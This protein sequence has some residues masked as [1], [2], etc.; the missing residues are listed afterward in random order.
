MNRVSIIIPTCGRP[1]KLWNCLRAL[2][3]Q[4]LPE[5][6]EQEIIVAVD[7]GWD[8]SDAGSIRDGNPECRFLELPRVGA[9]AARNA[10]IA[11]ATG[12][13]LIFSNDDT[14]PGPDWVREHL[15]AQAARREPG[16]VI[17]ETRWIEWPDMTVL[18]G[19]LR[20]TSMVFFYDRMKS[21]ESYGFRH[22]W[23]CNASA[24]REMVVG[25]GGFEESL[26]PVFYEDC[27]LAFRI[28]K[29]FGSGVYFHSAAVNV[30]DHRLSWSDYLQRE[31]ALGRMAIVLASVNPDCF[32]AIF[33]RR[34]VNVMAL[35]YHEWL[36]HDRGDHEAVDRLMR[37][38]CEGPLT[39]S[40][41]WREYCDVLYR[42]HLPLKRR[43]FRES[44]VRAASGL[45]ATPSE[46]AATSAG[47]HRP[48]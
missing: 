24:P 2:R 43:I 8:E 4:S 32:E 14:Y 25:V 28:E 44:F 1:R 30:H 19:L 29:T 17:G 20:D 34:D 36:N 37:S 45:T 9:A 38:V 35:E 6:V 47:T 18:D 21:G 22:F 10:A 39:E 13:L 46:R 3:H 31:S 26:R 16:M 27:E 40:C 5:G 11:A 7:G 33:G 12:S 42:T 41:D 15:V 48:R 23:T